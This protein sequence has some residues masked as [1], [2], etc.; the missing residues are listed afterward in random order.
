MPS[1]LSFALVAAGVASVFSLGPAFAGTVDD[2]AQRIAGMLS[3]SG[4]T[5]TGVQAMDIEFE[6]CTFRLEFSSIEDGLP[7]SGW[8]TGNMD[9]VLAERITLEQNETGQA[10]RF[11]FGSSVQGWALGAEV[12]PGAPVYEA[13]L[14]NDPTVAHLERDCDAESCLFRFNINGNTNNNHANIDLTGVV[15][16]DDAPVLL[17]TFQNMATVCTENGGAE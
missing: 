11:E 1:Q 7:I 3:F 4:N 17:T 2:A 12:F 10:V 14:N 13:L 6:D 9:G 16:R 5:S 15:T 8:M